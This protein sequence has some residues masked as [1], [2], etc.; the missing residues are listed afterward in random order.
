MMCP[1]AGLQR[2]SPATLRQEAEVLAQS[3]QRFLLESGKGS[4]VAAGAAH[5]F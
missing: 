5:A 3:E 2:S 4:K 1:R